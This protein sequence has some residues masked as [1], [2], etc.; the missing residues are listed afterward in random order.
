MNIEHQ[1]PM[2]SAFVFFLIFKE[3]Y[4]TRT[5]YSYSLIFI[6]KR[7]YYIIILYILYYYTYI[8]TITIIIIK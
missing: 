7:N 5:Y 4:T 3:K 1:W 2:L 6:D 8:H